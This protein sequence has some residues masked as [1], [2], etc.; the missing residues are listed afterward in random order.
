MKD[1]KNDMADVKREQVADGERV[2]TLEKNKSSVMGA[3][4]MA[5]AV[6]GV[7]MWMAN[8]TALA[9]MNAMEQRVI[10]GVNRAVRGLPPAVQP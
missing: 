2:T 9:E 8:R 1:V 5:V 10:T 3:W 7:F 6:S 4:A